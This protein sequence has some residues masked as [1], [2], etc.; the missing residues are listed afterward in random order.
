MTTKARV[1]DPVNQYFLYPR[2]CASTFGI[3]APVSTDRGYF[4]FGPD[5]VCY[6]KTSAGYRSETTEQQLYDAADDILFEESRIRLPFD[7]SEIITNLTHER[8]VEHASRYTSRLIR[9][10][11]YAF[12]PVLPI[13]LRSPL[14]TLYLES[15][16]QPRFPSWPVDTT[17]DDLLTRLLLLSLKSSGLNS[18]PFIWFWPD[19][20]IACSIMT[21]D[22][23]SEEGKQFCS[24]LM[25]VDEE[26]GVP[27]SFQIVPESRYSVTPEFIDGFRRRNFEVN[28][29]DLSHDGRLFWHLKEFK[30]R[31]K[32]INSYGRDYNAAGFRSA[33]LYRRQEWFDLLDFEYDMSVPNTGHYDPQ[34]GGCCT[35]MPYFIGNILE[36][37]VTTSQDHTVFHVF[38]SYSLDLWLSQIDSIISKAGLISFIVHPDYVIQRRAMDTYKDLLLE[39]R[40]LQS[41]RNLW[42]AYPGE[43]NRWWRDRAAMTLAFKNGE[44][45]IEGHGSEKASIAFAT[46]DSDRVVYTIPKRQ[47][48]A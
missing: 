23:E 26:F 45:V 1:T 16:Q 5:L 28:V 2:D 36:L 37:P 21:H 18:L 12:R 44:W 48:L 42:I 6:G 34:P 33:I 19:S 32:K 43:V 27:A 24:A 39:L 29:Q 3:T 7:L 4:R 38:K 46:L 15:R 47:L 25:D 8:Y 20:A 13:S 14:Q 31:V 30:N 10:L 22:V 9:Q 40:R 11:Y 17:V 35:V 41:T